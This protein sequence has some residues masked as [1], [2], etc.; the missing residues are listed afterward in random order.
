MPELP[1]LA[2]VADALHAALAGRPIQ[3]IVVTHYH[4]DHAGNAAWLG[5]RFNAPLWMTRGEFLT[6]HAVLQG[7][8]SFSAAASSA[9]FRANGMVP[10]AAAA[11]L[12]RGDLYSKLVPAFPAQHRRLMDGASV[13][14][15]GEDWRVIVCYG[16]APEHALSIN[17]PPD[18]HRAAT[19]SD[20]ASIIARPFQRKAGQLPKRSARH[21]VENGNCH[22]RQGYRL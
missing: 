21:K 20:A 7:V 2:V 19:G 3:R 14:L 12:A 10:A 9:L 18:F 17:P 15:G 4:P 8:A 11:L 16:H 22:V 5:E 1:D 6:V 13:N